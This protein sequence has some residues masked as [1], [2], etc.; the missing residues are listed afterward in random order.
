MKNFWIGFEKSAEAKE[1]PEGHQVRRFLLSNPVS[2]AI[3]AKKGKK[4]KAF[5]S[6]TKHLVGQG[7]KGMGIG[8]AAGAG[9]GLV[10]SALSKGRLHPGAGAAI[11]AL[12]GANLGGSV[13]VLKGNHDA[14][15]SR[16]HGEHSK[17]K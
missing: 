2:S 5:G 12:G 11:G 17:N 14:E 9:A 15:A 7:L 8:G 10:A 3:E 1:G 4:M 13:G 6:A 16:I